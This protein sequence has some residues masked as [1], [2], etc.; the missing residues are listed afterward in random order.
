MLLEKL[1]GMGHGLQKKI[2]YFRREIT[3]LTS[4]YV[5]LIKCLSSLTL[6]YVWYIFYFTLIFRKKIK[7][8]IE[9]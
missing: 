4:H 6:V 8:R 3:K 1:G 7:K 5:Q 2:L 9:N